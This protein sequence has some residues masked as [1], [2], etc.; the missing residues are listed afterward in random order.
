MPVF[1]Q[2]AT[3]GAKTVQNGGCF[4]PLDDLGQPVNLTASPAPVLVSGSL[5]AYVPTITTTG[6]GTGLTFNSGGIG[7][8]AGAVV[9]VALATG[10]TVDLTIAIE[11]NAFS[12][13][14]I[15]QAS[16][17]YGLAVLGDTIRLR[18]GDH[19]PT[20]TSV[21]AVTKASSPSGVWTGGVSLETA[22]WVVL[23]R[24]PGHPVRI[25]AMTVGQSSTGHAR[26]LRVHDLT[27][28]SPLIADENGF[29]P[30]AANGQFA[31]LSSSSN[32]ANVAVTNCVFR[33]SSQVRGDTIAYTGINTGPGQAIYCLGGPFWIEGNDIE[34]CHTG[35]NANSYNSAVAPIIRRNAV[36]RSQVDAMLIGQ[37]SGLLLEGN[38]ITDK[39]WPHTP[40]AVTGITPG[41]PTV[42]TVADTTRAFTNAIV[43]LTGFTGAFAALNGRTEL[44]TAKTAT[45]LTINLNT[46]GLTWDGLGGIIRCPTQKHG[47][48]IQ[49]SEN[50]GAAPNQIN[51]KIRG[52]LLSRGQVDGHWM[53]D[54]QGFFA[55]MGGTTADRTGWLIEGNIIECTLT[56]GIS[57]GKLIDST[58]RSNTVI[59]PLGLDGGNNGAPPA[60][61]I[62]G[63]AN[64]IYRDNL[65]TGYDLGTSAAVNENN[66][67][68][69]ITN[70][71]A[72]P[73]HPP[74]V[75]A[76]N[77]AFAAPPTAPDTVYDPKVAYATR[78]SGGT[79]AGY[80]RFPGAT[81][82]FD[83]ATLT[84]LELDEFM[85]FSDWLE[86][87]ILN[88]LLN[89]VN[90][91]G[92]G[93][94]TGLRGSAVPGSL[95]LSLHTADPGETGNAQTTSEA[96]Y[97]GYAR[98]AVVRTGSAWTVVG[99]V[100]SPAAN[101]TFPASSSGTTQRITHVCVGTAA[102]GAG[103]I[104]IRGT[105]ADGATPPNPWLDVI[106]G[107]AAV[108]GPS[109]T[110]SLN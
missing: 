70:R 102:T 42:V 3:Y 56:R 41:N 72:I 8:P 55:G 105:I 100:A 78:T 10:G 77:N 85:S 66:F 43:V 108:I 106:P 84:F 62:Q 91:A 23:T 38:V 98:V 80:A 44:L 63:G 64:N 103:Q 32:T 54:G 57:I 7:A 75:T 24:D 12:V 82:Y 27:F 19:N 58:V 101:I 61:I 47:D 83:F 13:A 97:A 34:G 96:T 6:P 53:P 49:F 60:I 67:L 88:L 76:Y 5:G 74:N 99:G 17:A 50:N 71:E 65:A 109:T 69:S 37:C 104:L 95:W 46:T 79:F 28:F 26:Y 40:L 25:G 15:Q 52:N 20:P 110:L 73:A 1:N 31:L 107:G 9:R 33:H 94:A 2:T 51:V 39:L 68:L 90:I 21:V 81:P 11:P 14:S 48:F 59:S 89:N 29:F 36:R 22:N 92:I 16:T 45:T 87:G 18:A 30:N 86:N 4:R 35:I 93:D